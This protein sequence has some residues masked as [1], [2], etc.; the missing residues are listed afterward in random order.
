[1]EGGVFLGCDWKSGFER[2]TRAGACS[3]QVGVGYG[4]GHATSTFTRSSVR[5]TSASVI[6]VVGLTRSSILK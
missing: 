2:N 5:T 6:P 1:M 4:W 3:C